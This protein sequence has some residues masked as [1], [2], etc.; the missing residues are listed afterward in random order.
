[1][2]ENDKSDWFNVS[3][4]LKRLFDKRA[5][6][7]VARPTS[8]SLGR[9]HTRCWCCPVCRVARSR[10]PPVQL[11]RRSSAAVALY[12]PVRCRADRVRRPLKDI[13]A[14]PLADV[15]DVN[16]DNLTEV[17]VL[18]ED[19]YVTHDETTSVQS[20]SFRHF[21]VDLH[22]YLSVFAEKRTII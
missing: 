21:E 18:S 10:C 15:E 8:L 11:R 4:G 20:T 14:L 5:V 13:L 17:S 1:L 2:N 9:P 16:D 3:R 7:S 19:G 22:V 12:G 6:E